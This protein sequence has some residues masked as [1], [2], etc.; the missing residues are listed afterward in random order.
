MY[1][2]SGE[3]LTIMAESR[4]YWIKL[5]FNMLTS[6]TV[7]FLMSQKDG[8]NYVILYQMLCLLAI[9]SNGELADYI[10]EVIIPFDEAKIQRDTKYFNIDTIRVALGLYQKLGLVYVQENGILK[11]SDFENLIGSESKAAVKQRNYRENK[12]PA[13]VNGGRRVNR[14]MI[15]L[16]NG[17]TRYVDEKRYG[18]NGAYA[19]DL[20][21]YKCEICG[22]EENILIHHNNGLSNEIQDLFA[23]CPSCHRNVHSGRYTLSTHLYTEMSTNMS[24]QENRYKSIDNRDI[25]NRD[26]DIYIKDSSYYIYSPNS[27]QENIENPIEISKN[28]DEFNLDSQIKFIFKT[29]ND[30]E[31]TIHHSELNAIRIKAIQKALVN[32]KFPDI[33][34]AI[35]NYDLVLRSSWYFN[36]RWSLEDF[37]NRSNGISTF[38]NEGSNWISFEAEVKKNPLLLPRDQNME[39]IEAPE[40]FKE[41]LR[42]L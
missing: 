30:M 21:N 10:G 1:A 42:N 41:F 16:P 11:I 15:L 2:T 36:Y 3:G 18:G 29:W 28:D 12:L 19:L 6:K 32:F 31:K 8:A 26:I 38:T 20:A 25:D 39:K 34:Q 24:T 4:F 17:K 37:L 40:C 33:L 13:L 9:N 7:D 5:K 23:L 14:E 27:S 35:Q 22:S